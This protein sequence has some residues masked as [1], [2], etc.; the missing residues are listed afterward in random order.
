MAAAPYATT[1]SSMRAIIAKKTHGGAS[2]RPR[3]SPGSGRSTD[4]VVVRVGSGSGIASAV[5]YPVG[6]ARANGRALGG[7]SG[8]SSGA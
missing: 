8:T 3:A 6:A 2:H 1:A 4:S 5:T 7:R